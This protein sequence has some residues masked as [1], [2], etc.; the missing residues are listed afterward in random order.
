[1]PDAFRVLV[2]GTTAD[3]IH[4]IRTAR[5]GEVVF[6]T[7]PDV[8]QA[9]EEPPPSGGEEVLCDLADPDAVLCAVAS[10][11]DAFGIVPAGVACFDCESMAL[12]AA[13]AA[14]FDLSYPNM[15]SIENCRDKGRSKTLWRQNGVDCPDAVTVDTRDDL[16][17][18]FISSG[19]PVVLKPANGS[20][21]ELVF[22]CDS[23]PACEAHY[24]TASE[25]L[26]SKE[27]HRLY[28]KSGKVSPAMVAESCIDGRE[29]SCDF[30]LT[31]ESLAIV[32]V[33]EKIR[34]PGSPFGTIGGYV[35]PAF[36]PPDLQDQL[37]EALE[38]AARALG[39]EQ[40]IAMADF[41]VRG[42]RIFFL[43][44][45]PRPGGDCLP[46]LIRQAL[47]VDML[48]LAVDCAA[49]RRVPLPDSGG[50]WR[51]MGV[52]LHAAGGGR[53][54]RIVF[55][56]GMEEDGILEM[57]LIRKP[58]HRIVMPPEDY[59]SWFLGHIILRL[60]TN[61]DP[62]RVYQRICNNMEIE[63]ENDCP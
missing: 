10:H 9:A 19:G 42:G 49:G 8:R 57:N 58:G 26:A 54:K 50:I 6:V 7:A 18:F 23:L 15:A 11:L 33:A 1:V 40:C 16:A 25:Q 56:N 43:E 32:R 27:N 44:I 5:P 47:G 48:S 61:D 29:Y 14:H 51:H 13:V 41:I 62:F 35:L 22:R 38:R 55:R 52:R 34:P 46:F 37:P 28:R 36:L 63:I 53:L 12:A 45:T 30:L 4:L 60:E 17:V 21:S 20:G 24:A 59:D 3:Y 2:I 39:L 31:G